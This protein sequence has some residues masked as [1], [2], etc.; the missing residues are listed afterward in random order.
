MKRVRAR[1]SSSV[2]YISK[3]VIIVV[4]VIVSSLSFTLGYYV[5]KK[6]HP[7]DN[8]QA[9]IV[10]KNMNSLLN[11]KEPHDQEIAVNDQAEKQDMRSYTATQPPHVSQH[12]TEAKQTAVAKHN[13]NP[14]GMQKTQPPRK[15]TTKI[16]Y[17][18]QAGAFKS[19]HEAGILK[20]RLA[21]KGYTAYI[22]QSET[23][24]HEKLYK[25]MIGKFPT[26]KQA[27]V[28]SL[29]IK[30]AEGLQTFVTFRTKEDVLR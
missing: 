20:E 8:N 11:D 3:W 24:T 14:H 16:T 23:K 2:F 22:I 25:V 6:Y 18:V 28:L 10:P 4:I 1:D 7:S 9:S 26:R 21:K 5:G 15:V 29:K 19:S 13:Q 17:T 30:K 27:E 12:T